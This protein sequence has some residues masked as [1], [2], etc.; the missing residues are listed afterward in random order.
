VINAS[1]AFFELPGGD[2]RQNRMTLRILASSQ[3][4]AG[5]SGVS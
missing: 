2:R 4:L 5:H 1:P 3:A